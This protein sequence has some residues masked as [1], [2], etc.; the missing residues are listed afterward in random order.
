MLL[1]FKDKHL[2]MIRRVCWVLFCRDVGLHGQGGPPQVSG[3]QHASSQP[4][5][6]EVHVSPSQTVRR[7]RTEMF[8][9]ASIS[10]PALKVLVKSSQ[11]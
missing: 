3:A 2:L 7:E 5:H 6:V 11:L 8:A 9:S 10:P 4:R 1:R